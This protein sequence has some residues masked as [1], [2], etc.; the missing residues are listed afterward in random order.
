MANEELLWILKQGVETWNRFRHDHPEEELPN[1][2]A[3]NLEGV[4]LYRAD[5]SNVV[6]SGA[7]L[8]G[9]NLIEANL[10]GANLSGAN[11][12]NAHLTNAHLGGA[13]LTGAYLTGA[14]LT[15]ANLFLTNLG[16][17]H[18]EGANLSMAT[19]INTDLRAANITGSRVYGASVWGVK[20]E[21]AKQQN[22]IIT[23]GNEATVTVDN[24]EVAQFIYLLLNNS[25]IRDVIDTVAKKAVLILGRFTPERMVV[26]DAI[27]K[28]LRRRDY[29]P[30]IF[31]FDKPSSRNITETV[32][33][34]AHIAL[35]VIA[36]ITDAKSIPQEL[37]R[38]VPSLP[39]VPVQPLLHS[40][41]NEY[42]MFRDFFDY[43]TVLRPHRYDD[44]DKL[45]SSLEE[46]VI[47][48]A[49]TK[50]KEIEERRNAF[51]RDLAR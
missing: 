26:L 32:S 5:L 33:T 36:D 15:G 2:A 23:P 34:L 49:A 22:L 21:Q 16:G 41:F 28:E 6:L 1:L 19:L 18:L 51:E 35:F 17:A 50:A 43:P 20:L 31:D 37:Q 4:P 38:I 46:R 11:L 3:A 13:I 9:A 8:S 45:L 24:L 14:F 30:I 12:T 39:S 10:A 47:V 27:R 40:S 48:P 44:L 7:Y 42:A 29:L 25:R